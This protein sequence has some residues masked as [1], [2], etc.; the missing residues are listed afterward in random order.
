MC[1][2]EVCQRE[3]NLL[4]LIQ[5]TLINYCDPEK[6]NTPGVLRPLFMGTKDRPTRQL[7]LRNDSLM[8]LPLEEVVNLFKS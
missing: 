4:L 1:K 6:Y 7:I 3:K 5:R 2:Q 8:R